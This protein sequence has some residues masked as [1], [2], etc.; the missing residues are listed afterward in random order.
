MVLETWEWMRS[1]GEC[2]ERGE[3]K[4]QDGIL[5]IPQRTEVEAVEKRKQMRRG[6]CGA[7]GGDSCTEGRVDSSRYHRE[8]M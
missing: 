8:V 1:P 2:V 6:C 5:G 3:K 7:Q 4:A